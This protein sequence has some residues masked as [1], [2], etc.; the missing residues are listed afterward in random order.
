M[1]F[2]LRIVYMAISLHAVV[3]YSAKGKTPPFFVRTVRLKYAEK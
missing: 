1:V 2:S 3:N